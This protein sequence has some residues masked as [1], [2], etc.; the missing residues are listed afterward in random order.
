ME[1]IDLDLQDHFGHLDLKFLEIWL[2]CVITCNGF[3]LESPNLHQI[4][5]FG[6][7]RLLLKMEVIEID[8]QGHLAI[9]PIQETGFI[10]AL[11][12]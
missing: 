4:C 12:Y 2:V 8:L 10:I 5:I 9:I 1:V 3:E 7:F 11:V 6:F